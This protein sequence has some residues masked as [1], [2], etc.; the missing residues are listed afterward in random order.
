MPYDDN[1]II[2]IVIVKEFVVGKK[3]WE[4]IL[5]IEVLECERG[6]RE[7]NPVVYTVLLLCREEIAPAKSHLISPVVVV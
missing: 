5:F 1:I 4:L 6:R 7:E 2:I 3:I